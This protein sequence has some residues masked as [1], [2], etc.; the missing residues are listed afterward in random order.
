MTLR[1]RAMLVLCTLA[2]MALLA[3]VLLIRERS[4]RSSELATLR[5]AVHDVDARLKRLDES[6]GS[7]APA[8]VVWVPS[9]A[10]ADTL[11]PSAASPAPPHESE[12]TEFTSVSE[13]YERQRAS[14]A[15]MTDALERTLGNQQVDLSWS[16]DTTAQIASSILE[17]AP[18]A[19]LIERKCGSTLCR[20]VLEHDSA[21]AQREL[22]SQIESAEP[23]RSGAV[24][25]YAPEA[26]NT[27]A[28]TT[29]FVIRA[30]Y[31]FDEIIGN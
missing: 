30:G 5:S 11:P 1:S 20:V 4:T 8:T 28:R 31:D 17:R 24:Y 9:P 13:L 10:P 21:T 18:R 26:P 15:E 27:A 12:Q 25:Q 29:V 6:P 22:A 14:A 3:W 2:G 19:R 23:F 16:R 7:R